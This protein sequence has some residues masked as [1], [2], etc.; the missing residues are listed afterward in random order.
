MGRN[1]AVELK[2]TEQIRI[3]TQPISLET[4]TVY[5]VLQLYSSTVVV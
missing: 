2:I 1:F 4:D 5:S 3:I